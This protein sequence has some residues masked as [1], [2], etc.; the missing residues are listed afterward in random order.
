MIFFFRD[1]VF[2][3]GLHLSD[4]F[5]LYFAFSGS[6]VAVT[7]VF[8]VVDEQEWSQIAIVECEDNE[9]VLGVKAPYLF[10]DW[11]GGDLVWMEIYKCYTPWKL[12]FTEWK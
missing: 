6:V 8:E 7:G 5:N 3:V 2:E 12:S 9:V 4:F 1:C 11:Q 10:V